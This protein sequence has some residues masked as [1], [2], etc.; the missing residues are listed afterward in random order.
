M[1]SRIFKCPIPVGYINLLLTRPVHR[2]TRSVQPLT[3]NWH[4]G[5]PTGVFPS[6]P[7][8]HTFS[9]IDWHPEHHL[10]K[11]AEHDTKHMSKGY[12]MMVQPWNQIYISDSYWLAADLTKFG[13]LLK[14]VTPSATYE[15]SMLTYRYR[16][17]WSSSSWR[18]EHIEHA[19]HQLQQW[20]RTEPMDGP[21]YDTNTSYDR[22]HSEVG[23][24]RADDP[25][26]WLHEVTMIYSMTSTY[27]DTEW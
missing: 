11:I 15:R 20:H 21:G 8:D 24:G 13:N 4:R 9:T 25:W 22:Q 7:L 12:I 3:T 14:S 27:H 1:V 6:I 17:W 2:T 10:A 19:H 16:I 18:A 23:T 26:T 5:F